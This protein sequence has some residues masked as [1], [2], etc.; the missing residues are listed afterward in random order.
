MAEL[1]RS[2]LPQ[3]P[4]YWEQLAQRIR[5]D[6]VGP[7]AAHAA[8]HD[9]WYGV[10]ARRAPWLVAVSAA[11]MLVLWLVL[12][13]DAA[14]AFRPIERLLEPSEVAGTL[15]GGPAPP[16]VDVL[17]VQFPPVLDVEARQ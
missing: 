11:A 6:A 9:A 7:L 3:E 8:A 15:V 2:Q 16:S 14:A 17:M 10:L 4:E 5:Q 1:P 12:P 13:P